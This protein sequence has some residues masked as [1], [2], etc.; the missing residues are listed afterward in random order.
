MSF[1]G[2]PKALHGVQI[3]LLRVLFR[4][5]LGP[6]F[7]RRGFCAGQND[8]DADAVL[9]PFLCRDLRHASNGLLVGAIGQLARDAEHACRGGEVDDPTLMLSLH[10]GECGLH[11]VE[12]ADHAALPGLEH[13]FVGGV[14]YRSRGNDGLRIVDDNI[15]GAVF[16]GGGLY[17]LIHPGPV[18]GVAGHG[19]TLAAQRLDLGDGLLDRLEAATGRNDLNPSAG[20]AES[21]PLADALSGTGHNS[22]FFI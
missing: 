2:S 16:F 6:G 12:R 22:N 4:E 9:A 3:D 20:K 13:V 17:D 10:V 7:R 11:I 21:D 18:S 15:D 14:F 19:K 8:V 1:S 5:L